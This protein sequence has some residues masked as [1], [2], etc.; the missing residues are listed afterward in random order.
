MY[1]VNLDPSLLA[2]RTETEPF[3][4]VEK[5]DKATSLIDNNC[6]L[7]INNNEPES[8]DAHEYISLRSN[9]EPVKPPKIQRSW[10]IRKIL[11]LPYNG[12]KDRNNENVP[13]ILELDSNCINI[14]RFLVYDEITGRQRRPLLH[15]FIRR[16]LET[17]EYSYLAEY[18]DRK[19]GVFKLYQPK[20]I[21]QLWQYVKGRNSDN[22]KFKSYRIKIKYFHR[23]LLLSGYSYCLQI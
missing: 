3:Y 10:K 12:N 4:P 19:T 9:V 8:N 16:I 7:P 17:D 13:S 14:K 5:D 23:S 2:H 1:S 18:I 15:E 22:G 11:S 6:T 20:Q 21:S